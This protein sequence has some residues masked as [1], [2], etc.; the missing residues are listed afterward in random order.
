[1]FIDK[2]RTGLW[3]IDVQERLYPHIDRY[4][5]ILERMCYV[6]EAAKLLHIPLF[7]TEQ[8]PDKLGETVGV[9]KDRLPEG[10]IIYPKSSFSGFFDPKIR[11]AVN[12]IPVKT[13]LLVGIE[14]HICVLQTAKDLLAGKKEVVVLNDAV[15]SRSVFDFST[16]MGELRDNGARI[17]NCET[18][19]YECIRDAHSEIFKELF[20][21][22]KAHA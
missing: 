3:V 2:E 10:Q 5:E 20:P 14:A 18:V 11:E 13:W 15:G 4:E 12:K 9:I 16:A 1:M 8:V 22:L 6:I 17:S 21:L 19:I 7:I